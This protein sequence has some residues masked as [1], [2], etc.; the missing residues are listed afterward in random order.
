MPVIARGARPALALA[1]GAGPDVL[2]ALGPHRQG[3]SRRVSDLVLI[4]LTPAACWAVGR[5]LR[6]ERR[7]LG[8][9]AAAQE[10]AR[11][12]R[13]AHDET[14]HPVTAVVVD[15]DAAAASTHPVD[16]SAPLRQTPRDGFTHPPSR[17][18]DA[19]TRRRAD[20][21]AVGERRVAARL[22]VTSPDV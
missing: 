11:I 17:R 22:S 2:L 15:A 8:A 13:D 19:Q 10:R 3:T 4:F 1:A 6:A 7:R 9:E 14:T 20:A 12:A 5:T 21:P 16:H 18:A